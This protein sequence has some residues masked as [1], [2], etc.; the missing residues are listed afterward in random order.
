[1]AVMMI[2]LIVG[3]PGLGESV[4]GRTQSLQIAELLSQKYVVPSRDANYL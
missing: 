3:F 2:L 4:L 1:M